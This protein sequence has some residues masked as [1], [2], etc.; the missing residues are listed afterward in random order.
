MYQM[1]P[2]KNLLHHSPSETCGDSKTTSENQQENLP[3]VTCEVEDISVQDMVVSEN[4]DRS[5]DNLSST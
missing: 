4:V 2:L 1:K 3:T 5:N